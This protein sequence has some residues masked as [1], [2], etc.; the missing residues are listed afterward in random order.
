[1]PT[2]H[3]RYQN[4]RDRAP[5]FMWCVRGVLAVCPDMFL[6]PYLASISLWFSEPGI[7]FEQRPGITFTAAR[8]FTLLYSSIIRAAQNMFLCVFSCSLFF[9]QFIFFHDLISFLSPTKS[10]VYHVPDTAV[11]LFC[12]SVVFFRMASGLLPVHMIPSMRTIYIIFVLFSHGVWTRN[13]FVFLVKRTARGIP[14]AFFHVFMKTALRINRHRRA[15][16][17]SVGKC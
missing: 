11:S 12:V 8:S 5:P 6:L 16:S 1:M 7:H 4:P 17:R 3:N 9:L 10:L 2:S 13:L 14:G 15:E